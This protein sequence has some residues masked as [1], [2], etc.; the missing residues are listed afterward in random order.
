MEII[1]TSYADHDHA[2]KLLVGVV[3]SFI[4]YA[5]VSSNATIS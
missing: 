5:Y 3:F 1:Q 4:I 2:S